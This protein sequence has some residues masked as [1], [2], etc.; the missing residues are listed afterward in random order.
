[1][2]K[3]PTR[4]R[5]KHIAADP[6]QRVYIHRTSDPVLGFL[7][8]QAETYG[9]GY[10]PPSLGG[11]TAAEILKDCRER[12]QKV[13]DSLYGPRWPEY[14]KLVGIDKQTIQHLTP[15]KMQRT[16]AATPKCLRLA[17]L[18]MMVHLQNVREQLN[19][20]E[21]E[22]WVAMQLTHSPALSLKVGKVGRKQD[23]LKKMKARIGENPN[24]S[25]TIELAESARA[26][27]LMP[28]RAVGMVRDPSLHPME[29]YRA[30]VEREMNQG[31]ISEMWQHSIPPVRGQTYDKDPVSMCRNPYD[32]RTRLTP[33]ELA[34][35]KIAERE[36]RKKLRELT[37]ARRQRR[38][39][40]LQIQ[41][42]KIDDPRAE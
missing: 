19:D 10:V 3:K 9:L 22:L 33:E 18:S 39:Q 41:Q 36:R 37:V 17:Q 38:R 28:L 12:T 21:R 5:Q 20:L 7:Y 42:G 34:R 1:V 40:Y 32:H 15:G 29:A 14:I 27:S 30:E 24:K 4:A 11:Q 16:N 13:A 23:A 25:R 2:I 31:H 6:R 35:H 8:R 26:F